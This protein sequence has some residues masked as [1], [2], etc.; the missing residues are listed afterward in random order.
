MT[1]A[2]GRS[3]CVHVSNRLGCSR[4]SLCLTLLWRYLSTLAGQRY[5]DTVDPWNPLSS[6]SCSRLHWHFM[7]S[8]T[9]VSS[10]GSA[11][12]DCV[13]GLRS[14]RSPSAQQLLERHGRGWQISSRPA[15]ACLFLPKTWRWPV[16]GETVP[17]TASASATLTASLCARKVCA[18][19]P[20][21][22]SQIIACR[23]PRM[24]LSFWASCMLQNFH[25]SNSTHQNHG[26]IKTTRLPL[27]Y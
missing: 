17:D 24:N 15:C 10:P 26:I 13:L 1:P 7:L 6:Q 20:T 16:G 12:S 11:D 14:L 4:R 3:D 2:S 23:L 21:G 5:C 25:R 18:C 9:L 27:P 8:L 22:V 19:S